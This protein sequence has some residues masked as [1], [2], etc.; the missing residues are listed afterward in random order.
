[1][2]IGSYK[3]YSLGKNGGKS[4]KRIQSHKVYANREFLDICVR[5]VRSGH[6]L[7]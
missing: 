3:S 7:F 1:M 6:F 4:T 2:Q 5:V